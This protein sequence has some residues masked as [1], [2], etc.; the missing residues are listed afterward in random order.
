[1]RATLD[2]VQ[3][4]SGSPPPSPFVID[5]E[6]RALFERDLRFIE[7][8]PSSSSCGPY[9]SPR[10]SVGAHYVVLAAQT[11]SGSAATFMRLRVEG[12]DVVMCDRARPGE[13]SCPRMRGATYRRL[14]AG[15]EARI[16]PGNDQDFATITAARMPLVQFV[17]AIEAI[18]NGGNITPPETGSAGLAAHRR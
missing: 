16:D 1:M 13:L 12:D 15:V 6:R 3:A 17:S 10:Y 14:F 4:Y 2:V 18:R 9:A 7:T 11:S 8:H 5:A